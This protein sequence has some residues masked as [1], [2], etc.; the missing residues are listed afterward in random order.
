MVIKLAL[1]ILAKIFESVTKNSPA[2][3]G[4]NR[5]LGMLFGIIPAV[6][7]LLFTTYFLSTP[8]VKN[9]KD[10]INQTWLAPIRNT[11]TNVVYILEEPYNVNEAIQ[12]LIS[13]PMSLTEEDTKLVFE[14]LISEHQDADEIQDFVNEHSVHQIEQ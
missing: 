13:D 4:I 5:V 1:F 3:S 8:V 12:K 11:A 14:W 7:L 2:V 10:I 9:G 6:V